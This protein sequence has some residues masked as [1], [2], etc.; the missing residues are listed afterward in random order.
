[1]LM[2]GRGGSRLQQFRS[3]HNVDIHLD[4]GGNVD[5]VGGNAARPGEG[6][7]L[8][9]GTS[10]GVHNA[11]KEIEQVTQREPV[12]VGPVGASHGGGGSAAGRTLGWHEEEQEIEEAWVAE[13]APPSLQS[14]WGGDTGNSAGSGNGSGPGS[15]VVW[16]TNVSA[17]TGSRK[18][19]DKGAGSGDCTGTLTVTD[20]KRESSAVTKAARRARVQALLK[21]NKSLAGA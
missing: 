4:K 12:R 3:T 20:A 2:L 19:V 17:K 13:Y 18:A 14:S 1:M 5:G 15:P 7:V 21:S 9:V 6:T 11:C 10:G 16:G 8:V